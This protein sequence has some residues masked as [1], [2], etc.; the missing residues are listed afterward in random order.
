MSGPHSEGFE[1]MLEVKKTCRQAKARQKEKRAAI[2]DR[3][4]TTQLT[5]Y[6]SNVQL[7]P[8]STDEGCLT[9]KWIESNDAPL[10]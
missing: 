9:E 10:E 5:S 8:L 1:P 6:F 2:L 4:A 7:P 3:M